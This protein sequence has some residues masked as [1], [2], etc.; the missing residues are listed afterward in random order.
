MLPD[1]IQQFDAEFSDYDHFGL[2]E[3]RTGQFEC[4]GHCFSH[5]PDISHPGEGLGKIE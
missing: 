2:S 4:V 5:P 1:L 3:G